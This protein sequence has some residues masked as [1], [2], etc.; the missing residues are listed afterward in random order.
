MLDFHLLSARTGE[1][2]KIPTDRTLIGTADHATVHT[3]S[4]P[5][6]AALTVRYPTGWAVFGLSEDPTVTFNREPLGPAQRVIPKKGDLL[7]VG[8][9]RFT[10]MTPRNEADEPPTAEAP[11]CFV[12]IRSPDGMEECRAVDHDL[13][14]GRLEICHVQLADSRL[15]RLSALLA[16]HDGAWYIHTLSK[17]ALGRNRKAVNTYTRIEDGDEL[18]IGPLVVRVEIRGGSAEKPALPTATGSDSTAS[19]RRP[20]ALSKARPTSSATD[21]GESTDDGTGAVEQELGA[22]LPALIAGAQQLEKWLK[23]QNP[24]AAAPKSGLG[25]WL[26][27]QRDK[28]RRF[29]LD[30][31]ETTAAR[32][33]RTAGKFDEALAILD[34]AIRARPDGPELLR[35]LY[36][37]YE[38]AGLLDFCYRPLRHIEKLAEAR[39]APDPW[40]LE[41]LARLCER[42]SAETKGMADRAIEYWNKLEAATG[43]SYHRQ[44]A[45]ALA[46]RALR[47]GGYANTSDDE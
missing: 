39:G 27:A 7:T 4:G 29:W 5:Y 34:R 46:R 40:V 23:N 25:G 32:S 37:L 21:F 45:D 12:Y 13:L 43:Q 17:K 44:R 38:A 10:F 47:E 14:F 36:R 33:L 3:E 15:S 20:G 31:P 1:T 8:G 18:L 24:P 42:L 2:V 11:P 30:T 22:H 16:A 19:L 28:L 35:E 41:T 6:L 9:E 26:G